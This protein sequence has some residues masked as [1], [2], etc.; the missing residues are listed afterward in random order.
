VQVRESEV[1]IT[2]SPYLEARYAIDNHLFSA[3]S[4]QW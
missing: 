2:E 1:T 4:S 3:G